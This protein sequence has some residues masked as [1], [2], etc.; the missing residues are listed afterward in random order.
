MLEFGQEDSADWD[1]PPEIEDITRALA[2]LDRLPVRD[3]G[4]ADPVRERLRCWQRVAAAA[5]ARPIAWRAIMAVTDA[6]RASRW[7]LNGSSASA[8]IVTAGGRKPHLPIP[9]DQ[10]SMADPGT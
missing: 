7:I 10:Q 5:V 6:L 9:S 3:D 8:V 2:I 1:Y 4:S